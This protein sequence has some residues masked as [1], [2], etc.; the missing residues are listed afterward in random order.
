MIPRE[1]WRE[2]WLRLVLTHRADDPRRRRDEAIGWRLKLFCVALTR[3]EHGMRADGSVSYPRALL[4]ASLGTSEKTITD[5]FRDALDVGVLERVST[6]KKGHTA[7]YRALR[8]PSIIERPERK[9]SKTRV[10]LWPGESEQDRPTTSEQDSIPALRKGVTLKSDTDRL[11]ASSTS[12]TSP[13]SATS[14]AKTAKAGKRSS[15]PD[16]SGLSSRSA[17]SGDPER[18]VTDVTARTSGE[19]EQGPP[20]GKV[21]PEA[22]PRQHDGTRPEDYRSAHDVLAALASERYQAVLERARENNPDLDTPHLMLAAAELVR[23]A[24]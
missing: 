10:P 15:T 13:P 14:G 11:P 4:A 3:G 5:L 16:P 7:V 12:A 9:A 2:E 18:P 24:A 22:A 1:C 21:A 23:G 19:S 20:D 6:G 8:P 17:R